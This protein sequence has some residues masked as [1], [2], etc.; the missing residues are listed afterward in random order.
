MVIL[1]SFIFA[2]AIA[3]AAIPEALS[4]IVTIVLS[5]GTNTMSKKNSIIRKLP[6]VETLGSTSVIC[7][8]KTGTLTMNKMTV[9]EYYKYDGRNAGS[10]E[11]VEEGQKDLDNIGGFN[12]EDMINIAAALCNDSVISEDGK[13]IGDPYRGSLDSIC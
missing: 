11:V 8:D 7:T 1:N 2:V 5:M 12:T 3:V 10:I 4:S 6:A 9:L 13:E